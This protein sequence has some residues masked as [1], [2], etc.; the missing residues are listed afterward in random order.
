MKKWDRRTNLSLKSIFEKVCFNIALN[1]II[2]ESEKKICHAYYP[3][4][5]SDLTIYSKAN[6]NKCDNQQ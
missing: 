1:Q 3:Y 4:N 6:Y 2:G 5:Q